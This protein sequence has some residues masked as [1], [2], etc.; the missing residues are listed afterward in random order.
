MASNLMTMDIRFDA[1]EFQRAINRIA[2]C[3]REEF[4]VSLLESNRPLRP[5]P[6]QPISTAWPVRQLAP[7]RFDE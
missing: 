6:R 7:G 3:M 2:E 5:R 1:T 4:A